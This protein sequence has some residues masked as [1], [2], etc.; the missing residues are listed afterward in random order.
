MKELIDDIEKDIFNCKLSFSSK[1]KIP[2]DLQKEYLKG[3][4]DAYNRVI[5]R[6]ELNYLYKTVE[7]NNKKM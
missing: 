6:I 4:I 5:Y 2:N 1:R 7:K 3:M